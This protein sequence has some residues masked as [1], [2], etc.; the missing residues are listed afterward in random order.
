MNDLT[1][2]ETLSKSKHRGEYVNRKIVKL[3]GDGNAYHIELKDGE[4]M[5]VYAPTGVET[6]T[7]SMNEVWLTVPQDDIK[8][9]DWSM[10][11][12]VIDCYNCTS[13]P[14]LLSNISSRTLLTLQ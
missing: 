3:W 7:E 14:L 12:G 13:F 9:N 11:D 1:R 6:S 4:Q 10:S 5:N 8:R 2:H